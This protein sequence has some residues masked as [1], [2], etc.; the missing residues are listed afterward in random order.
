[1]VDLTLLKR[2]IKR[3]SQNRPLPTHLFQFLPFAPSR[4]APLQSRSFPESY[5]TGRQAPDLPRFWVDRRTHFPKFREFA[6]CT[7]MLTET[8]AIARR[9]GRHRHWENIA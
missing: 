9:L 2:E 1:M 8:A 4:I 7:R 5:R 6:N 3:K